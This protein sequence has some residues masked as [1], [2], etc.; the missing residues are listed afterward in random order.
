MWPA[1]LRKSLDIRNANIYYIVY[2]KN[3]Y[4]DRQGSS[5]A[6]A[7]TTWFERM[8]QSCA[9]RYYRLIEPLS[10]ILSRTQIHPHILTITG[11]TLALVAANFFRIDRFFWGGVFIILAGT[12]D[13][14]DGR[15]ARETGKGST[16]G[17]LFDSTIDRYS[18]IAVF[19]GLAWYYYGQSWV[20]VLV[21][22]LAMAGS[23]MVSYIRARSEGLGMECKVGFM[24]RQWRITL[25]TAGALLSAIPGSK[26]L[27]MAL[28][29][30]AIA[31]GANITAIQRVAYIHRQLQRRTR[32]HLTD[33]MPNKE[34]IK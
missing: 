29:L 20:M 4:L 11:F 26:H 28:A 25:L 15:V 1:V 7:M 32:E 12:C 10:R 16:Y 34:R 24:P 13:V 2:S 33:L 23:M 3:Q 8:D 6:W 17:A 18:E 22:L 30:W 5:K 14:L 9:Q 21:I 31:I 19:V 27:P